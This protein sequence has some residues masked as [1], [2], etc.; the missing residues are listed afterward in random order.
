MQSQ[1][2][3]RIEPL[4]T[5]IIKP[6]RFNDLQATLID[7]VHAC[8]ERD[9]Q[10]GE[11]RHPWFEFNYVAHGCLQ[12]GIG[13]I[14]FPATP[15]TFILIPPGVAHS[16]R[17]LGETPDIGFCLRW[18]IEK[19][20]DDEHGLYQRYLRTMPVTRPY[21][22]KN[23]TI[24]ALVTALAGTREIVRQQLCFLELLCQFMELWDDAP[25]APNRDR[26]RQELQVRQAIIYLAEYHA[27][28]I[29]VNDLANSL[30]LS[31]R[32][33]ARI[34]RQVTGVTIIEKLNDIRINQAKILLRNTDKTI[35]EIARQVGFEN[36]F[37]FSSLFGKSAFTTPSE[38][39]KQF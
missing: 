5:L 22:Q 27:G 11:H 6:V 38:Y 29:A 13:N 8:H 2:E 26:S 30:N 4:Q 19:M 16:S 17:N 20:T 14:W 3:K 37:Y 35:K 12:T 24:T 34:F 1:W 28:P 25:D 23:E 15:G 32:H 39:R 36:E 33:L 21:C 10:V 31:Y 18:Q 7:A 9:W